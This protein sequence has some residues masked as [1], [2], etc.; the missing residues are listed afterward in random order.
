MKCADLMKLCQS[1]PGVGQQQRTGKINEIAFSVGDQ[2]FARFTTGAPIQ[3]RFTVL[4]T[5]DKLDQCLNPPRVTQATD[6]PGYW[7]SVSRVENI[8]DELIQQWLHWA[9]DQVANP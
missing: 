9:Y 3:W 8:D 4:S 7:L 1:L 6:Y 2:P 5:A